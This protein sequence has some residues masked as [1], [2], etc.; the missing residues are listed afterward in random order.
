LLRKDGAT[1]NQL[2]MSGVDKI[3][4]AMSSSAEPDV[5]NS[6]RLPQQGLTRSIA[7]HLL[8]GAVT[9]AI[10]IACVPAV[11]RA[12]DPPLAAL[13]IASLVGLI[14]IEL[15]I[16][17]FEGKRK[18]AR[19]SL[20]G[21][22]LYREKW[23]ISRYFTVV[24]VLVFICIVAY[25]IS[26]PLDRVWAGAAFSWLPPWYVFTSVKQYAGFGRLALSV[27]FG[28]RIVVFLV[29]S[30]VQEMYFRAYLLP[31]IS[32]F[33]IR[34]VFLNCALYAIYHFWLPTSMPGLF[35]ASLPIA[36]ATWM[37]KNYRVGMTTQVILGFLG[38]LLG[39]LAVI[40]HS[41]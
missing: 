27:T 12:G 16:L 11:T 21:I 13:L 25:G 19:W 26:L 40:H 18:N 8:P 1:E 14:P 22:L 29:I 28:V 3:D 7:L 20:D 31:R 38:S 36:L 37:S 5:A 4:G 10:Y 39:L 15:G 34:A 41:R 9:T 23:P 35:L 30:A 24:P 33:G 6:E 17:I 32:R 2:K